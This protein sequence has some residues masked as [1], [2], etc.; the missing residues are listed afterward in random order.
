MV[1]QLDYEFEGKLATSPPLIPARLYRS[2]RRWHGSA[3]HWVN[4]EKFMWWVPLPRQALDTH[5]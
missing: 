3:S 5:T 2:R 4:S 1:S